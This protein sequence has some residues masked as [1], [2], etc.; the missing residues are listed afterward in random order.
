S[1]DFTTYVALGNSLTAGYADGTLSRS[2]QSHSYPAILAEQF[3]MAGGG[4]FKQPLLPGDAG[5]PSAKLVLGNT[6]GCDGL[7][8]LKAVAYQGMMDTSG[9]IMNIAAQGPFNNV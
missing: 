8:S 7:A 2:G 3:R 5:W 6:V 1:A 9:S 4:D